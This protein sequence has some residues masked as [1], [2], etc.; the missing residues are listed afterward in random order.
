VAGWPIHTICSAMKKLAHILLLW[1]I[2]QSTNQ[3][4]RFGVVL[5]ARI[6]V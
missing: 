4:V 1:P 6:L 3:F 5:H 2:D